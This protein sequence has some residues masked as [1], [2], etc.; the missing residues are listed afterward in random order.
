MRIMMEEVI[1]REKAETWERVAQMER[2]VDHHEFKIQEHDKKFLDL[3]IAVAA[4][5]SRPSMTTSQPGSNSKWYSGSVTTRRETQG[6]RGDQKSRPSGLLSWARWTLATNRASLSQWCW[7]RDSHRFT[8]RVTVS[9]EK[10]LKNVIT[11]MIEERTE[12]L[13][14]KNMA[15]DGFWPGPGFDKSPSQ[16][17]RCRLL[18]DWH[19][20][21]LAEVL[22]ECG[23]VHGE[24]TH[25]RRRGTSTGGGGNHG[26]L[27][28]RLFKGIGHGVD[29]RNY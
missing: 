26:H 20:A 9:L 4:L 23:K 12:G 2:K 13:P 27:R 1:R 19:N 28:T 17:A 24:L 25:T 3:E 22:N 7:A 18:G 5:N 10:E 16:K 8:A 29:G 11:S 6:G 15:E 21:I 14:I